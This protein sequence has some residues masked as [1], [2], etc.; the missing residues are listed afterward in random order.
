MENLSTL[1][2]CVCVWNEWDAVNAEPW[3]QMR[4]SG[5]SISAVNYPQ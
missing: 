3:E 4:G 2:S 1:M 5:Q